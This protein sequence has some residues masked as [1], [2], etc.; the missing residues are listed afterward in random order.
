MKSKLFKKTIA[1]I[2]ALA[3]VASTFVIPMTANAA[4]TYY[5]L[6]NESATDTTGWASANFPD[7]MSIASD[8]NTSISKYFL[9]KNSTGRGART[10]YYNLP[11]A[12]KTVDENKKAVLEF[13]F[14][15]RNGG[16][17]GNN[18][19]AF[20]SETGT[21]I[22]N[23][24][25]NKQDYVLMITQPKD[26]SAQFALNGTDVY[27]ANYANETWAHAKAVLDFAQKDVLVTITSLDGSTTYYET[28]KV[29]MGN[30]ASELTQIFIN[31]ARDNSWAGI[32]NVVVRSVEDGD[33]VGTYYKVTFDVD[34]K[35]TVKSVKEGEKVEE[36]PDS[37][38]TGYIFKGWSKDGSD[39]LMT[40][41]DVLATAIT[42]DTTFTAVYEADTSYIE[43]MV[44]A[45]FTSFPENGLLIAG[46]D[47][48]TAASNLI[49]IKINGE[50]GTD[51]LANPDSRV[52][53]LDVKYELKGFRWVASKNEPTTDVIED[54]YCDSYGKVVKNEDKSI[55]FQLKSH[56]FNYYGEVVATVTYNGQTLSIS[57]PLAY[58]GNTANQAQ[59]VILPRGG[60]IADY[61]SYS[62]DMVGYK[63]AI[64]PD[65]KTSV[66]P[67]TDN[68]AAYGGNVG[69]GVYLAEEEGNKFLKIKTTGSNSS[70]FA[71]NQIEAVT[72]TQVVFRQKV[73]FYNPNSSIILKSVN[74]VTWTA[75]E[76]TSFSVN[77]TGSELNINNN[78]ITDAAT[79]IWYEII[80]TSDVTSGKCCAIVNDAEGNKLGESEIVS[81]SDAGSKTPTYYMY[82]TPD[83]SVGEL[84]FKD[85]TIYRAEMD[86]ATLATTASATTLAIPEEGAAPSTANLTVSAKTTEGYEAIGAATW[87][88]AN[89]AAG[90]T[91]TPSAEDSHMAT[92]SVDSTASAGTATVNVTIGGATKQIDFT[93]TA[94]KDS[95]KFADPVVNSISIPL[96]DNN[97]VVSYPVSVIDKD[98]ND[99]AGKT[100]SL[101]LYDQNNVNPVTLNGITLE[102]G[103]LTVT[104]DAVPT[105]VTIRA[106]STNSNNEEI[107]NT[108]KVTI[109]GLAFDLGTA[110]EEAVANGYTPVTSTTAYS[111]KLGYGIEGAATAGGTASLEDADTDYLEG[112]YT[113]KV[114]VPNDKIYK[115]TLNYE[116]NAVFEKISTDLSGVVRNNAAMGKVEYLAFV[117]DGVLDIGFDKKVS[118]IV[119][120]KIERE[121]GI[122]PHVYTV[123]DSTIANNGSWAYVLNRDFANYSELGQYVTFTNNGRGGKNLSSYYTGG[124]LWDRVVTN[125]KPG[126]Y[127]MIGDMGTNGMGADFEGSFKY[128]VDACLALGAKVILNSYSPH[129]AVGDYASGYNSATQKFNSY[130]QDAYDNIVRA[131]YEERKSELAGFIDIGKNADTA[132]NAYVDDYAANGYE[133]RD[134]AA[135]AIISCFGDHNHYSNGTIAAQLMIEGY[136]GTPGIVSELIRIVSNTEPQP[137]AP[138]ET[139]Q[140]TAPAE[141]TQPTTPAETAQ[142][143]APATD[144][145]NK[146]TVTVYAENGVAITA[147]YTENGALKAIKS[148]VDVADGQKVVTAAEGERVFAWDSLSGMKPLATKEVS[149]SEVVEPTT[150]AETAQPGGDDEPKETADPAAEAKVIW[151]AQKDT[152]YAAGQDLGNGLSLV[153]GTE[154]GAAPVYSDFTNTEEDGTVTPITKIVGGVEL[155]GY[156]SATT[157]NGSWSGTSVDPS[158]TTVIKYTAAEDGVLTVYLDNVGTDKKICVGQ[159]GMKKGEIEAAATYGTGN[160]MAFPVN[161]KAGESYYVYV[162]GSKGRFCGAAFEAGELPVVP[163][164]TDPPASEIPAPQDGEWVMSAAYNSC[165]AGTEL[166]KGL[167]TLFAD[168][169][170]NKKYLSSD[171]NGTF[172][173]GAAT[174]TALKYVAWTDGTLTVSFTG[175]G[176]PGSTGPKTMYIV[177]EGGK[178]TEPLASVPNESTEKMDGSI[179]ADVTAGTT[180]Y[181][182]GAGTKACFSGASFVQK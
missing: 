107:T 61:N 86:G 7:G 118:S 176:T 33:I 49:G 56:P 167:T 6:D 24:D 36:L 170:N 10:A 1:S 21:P 55:D 66:D 50:L 178:Q 157:A 5:T 159:E 163:D 155:T 151:K 88:V 42:A 103:V 169:K 25:Y 19:I 39:T 79:G 31:A 35:S 14:V 123:G 145:P 137:T 117:H 111:E 82:R 99:I 165:P 173:D 148:I 68:W 18:Q 171:D 140:P 47:E 100:V 152:A 98:G 113:F 12:A 174:G 2:S 92:I 154:D 23:G 149:A 96:D 93:I 54:E 120:E 161:V 83:N 44:S 84:D 135:Q 156:V 142:P 30:D 76:A 158:K 105:V 59:N 64:S 67:V 89:D 77:F 168:T 20:T 125:I 43:P 181:I 81:F 104:K 37:S 57:K 129:G 108:V 172:S 51:L 45:E 46:A 15:L 34:G 94:S 3:M 121:A 166:M 29:M 132:F 87:T 110:D 16:T 175:L 72:D 124:E 112:N 71:A 8:S 63:A 126:D 75:G 85:V 38:K 70:S 139:A 128:Y 162:A 58:L 153:F 41:E 122:K 106:T 78:R 32:D 22:G 150:P 62:P 97:T 95:I 144:D 101:A 180:Y 11:A 179:S 133:S 141:T 131:M 114:N 80:V 177:P 91:V 13:D 143:T 160:A 27:S 102:N 116:G 40:G 26:K 69:R 127:V 109:H 48:N 4:E 115:V 138:A 28:S 119:I 53:D 73:R 164:Q 146:D 90:I 17:N 136:K 60:Y 52:K 134:A 65:N 182:Y 9:Y 130:R 74:P 147:E